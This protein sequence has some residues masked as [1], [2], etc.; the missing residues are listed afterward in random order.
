M[1]FV[2]FRSLLLIWEIERDPQIS[3]PCLIFPEIFNVICVC[4][5]SRL[6]MSDS[7]V[8]PWQTVAHHAPLSM[9]FS[10]QEYWNAL[11]FPTSNII[12]KYAQ[13]GEWSFFFFV[14]VFLNRIW[15]NLQKAKI[16]YS[17]ILNQKF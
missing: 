11:P 2:G 3:F 13:F 6:V 16:H 9:G 1:L 5:L 8:T 17:G 12:C 15:R 7:F 10:R 4:V 14:F